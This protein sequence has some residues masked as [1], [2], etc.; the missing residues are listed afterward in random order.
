[1]ASPKILS[2][3]LTWLFSTKA[4][5]DEINRTQRALRIL[6]NDYHFF[7]NELLEKSE[8]VKIHAQ[9]LQKLMIEIYKT[10]NNLSPSYSGI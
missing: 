9:N 3:P 7:F 8:S 1:M 4:A 2:F 5:N 6:S 10:M